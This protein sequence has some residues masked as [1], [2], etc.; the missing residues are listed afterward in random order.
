MNQDLQGN[1]RGKMNPETLVSKS[2]LFNFLIIAVNARNEQVS[3]ISCRASE[4][5]HLNHTLM[6]V[7]DGK[8][9]RG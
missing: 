5:Q 9:H 3:L 4:C 6:F 7:I 8:F 1:S 2:C